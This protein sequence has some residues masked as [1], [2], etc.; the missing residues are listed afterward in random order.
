MLLELRVRFVGAMEVHMGK[1]TNR[2]EENKKLSVRG[3]GGG[4]SKKMEYL[5]WGDCTYTRSTYNPVTTVY[6][7]Y[8]P[9]QKGISQE[10]LDD[11]KISILQKT[12]ISKK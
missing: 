1:H 2:A 9:D 7:V 8:A 10:C 11:E 4:V 6:N 12:Y 5:E 3:E